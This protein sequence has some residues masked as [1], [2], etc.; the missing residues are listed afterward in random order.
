MKTSCSILV[1][2]G[3]Y[4]SAA[5]GKITLGPDG[6]YRGVTVKISDE[7]PDTNCPRI[8]SNLKVIIKCNEIFYWNIILN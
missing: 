5:S 7:I 2:L 6:R 1:S 4:L 3:L 8:L